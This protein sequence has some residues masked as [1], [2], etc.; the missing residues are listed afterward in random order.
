M[1]GKDL[2]TG[3]LGG[4]H[5]VPVPGGRSEMCPQQ[6][7]LVVDVLYPPEWMLQT[8]DRLPQAIV[9]LSKFFG[10]LL[11]KTGALLMMRVHVWN[12][13]DGSETGWKIFPPKK[14]EFNFHQQRSRLHTSLP[15]FISSFSSVNQERIVP[16][17]M[18]RNFGDCFSNTSVVPEELLKKA[19]DVLRERL[20]EKKWYEEA[21]PLARIN[22]VD[23]R[24]REVAVVL[25]V[26]GN[27]VMDLNPVSIARLLWPCLHK[28]RSLFVLDKHKGG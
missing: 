16:V 9:R 4:F 12:L 6:K 18:W 27:L 24:L 14:G 22:Y 3:S 28:G 17:F 21:S 20:Q 11:E 10:E 7:L 25:S 5:F 8:A 26:G 15:L 1:Q 2:S 23:A 19:E 13:T